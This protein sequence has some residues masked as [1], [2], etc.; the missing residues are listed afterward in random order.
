VSRLAAANAYVPPTLLNRLCDRRLAKLGVRDNLTSP[1]RPQIFEVLAD[2]ARCS[3]RDLAQASIHSLTQAPVLARL[4]CAQIHLSDGTPVQLLDGQLRSRYIRPPRHAQFCP[5]CLRE[6]AYQ[7]RAWVLSDVVACLQHRRL[8]LED[9]PA[10]GARV[11]VQDVA[12]G[13]CDTC[14]ADLAH[15]TVEDELTPFGLFTQSAIGRWWGLEVPEIDNGEWTLV[16]QPP[17]ILY[18]LF[19][20]LQQTLEPLMSKSHLPSRALE[21]RYRVQVQAFQALVDWPRGFCRFLRLCLE[22]DVR[23]YS[24]RHR[25]TLETSIELSGDARL[26]FW[27]MHLQDSPVDYNFTQVAV[28]R[29]LAENPV[30]LRKNDRRLRIRV[31][32][33]EALQRI[34]RPMA[35][36]AQINL[37]KALEGWLNSSGF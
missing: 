36:R 23:D 33:D 18:R 14:D 35:Q 12:S 31:L 15:A 4:E 2:L 5:E 17:R 32:P 1:K 21:D 25:H 22:K 9:C 3:A 20:S 19:T 34:A 30:E 7:R 28:E 6:A 13:R 24:Y 37:E 10:C 11:E 26:T 29:F 16:K 27:L 8:L